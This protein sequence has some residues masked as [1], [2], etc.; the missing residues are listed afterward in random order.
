MFN[1]KEQQMQ[2][3]AHNANNIIGKGSTFTGNVHTHGNIRVEGK[4]VGDIV[5][6][7]KVVIG[8]SAIIEGNVKAQFAEVEGEV[9]GSLIISDNLVLKPS[10]SIKGDIIANKL[11]VE[12]GAK[13]DGQCKMGQQNMKIELAEDL[14][15]EL[16]E[17][18]LQKAV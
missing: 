17:K 13:F 1:N 10:C 6:K 18:K 9:K 11:V 5:S 14:K 3:E 8:N 16:E 2:A 7:S 4:V 12:A 15:K